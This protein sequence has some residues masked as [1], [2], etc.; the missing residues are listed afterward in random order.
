[1]KKL[2]V[3]IV[4]VAIGFVAG[5]ANVNWNVNAVQ[6]SPDSPA[7]AGWLVEIYASSVGYDY[8]KAAAGEITAW[9]TGATSSAG[10]TFRAAGT[11]NDGLANGSSGSFYMV[12]YDN[13]DISKAKNFVKSADVEITAGAGGADVALGFGAMLGTSLAANKFYGQSWTAAGSAAP[14]P[15]SG[16]LLL[17]G[18]A[19]LALKRKHA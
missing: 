12:I 18:M 15:T 2:M 11:V 16:L 6:G 1:M 10:S 14:E 17:L 4:A 19:G 5:A 7:A 13:A 8:A 9:G 3:A